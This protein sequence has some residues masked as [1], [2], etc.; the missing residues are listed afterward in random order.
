MSKQIKLMTD[1]Y[2]YPLWWMGGQEIGDI[3][4]K[5]LP[6]SQELIKSLEQWQ[7]GY[8]AILDLEDPASSGFKTLSQEE[9]F[10]QEGIRLWQKLKQELAPEYTVFYFSDRLQKII[11]DPEELQQKMNVKTA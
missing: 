2:C 5:T 9:E 1:Y 3:D 6:L 8:D 7:N 4:P 11:T 10:E